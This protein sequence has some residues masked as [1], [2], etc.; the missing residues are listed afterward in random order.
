MC[1]FWP[2]TFYEIDSRLVPFLHSAWLHAL[3]SMITF[4]GFFSHG[5]AI[6][7]GGWDFQNEE[8]QTCEEFNHIN[9][10]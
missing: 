6:T 9:N 7:C 5:A 10:R 4:S 3:K 8:L 1:K 2:N